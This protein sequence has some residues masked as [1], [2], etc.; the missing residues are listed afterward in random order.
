VHTEEDRELVQPVFERIKS[1]GGVTAIC[2]REGIGG[3]TEKEFVIVSCIVEG[4]S[5]TK[6]L[7][8]V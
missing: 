3:D 6:L 8:G 1:L 4:D 7:E 5:K 2:R